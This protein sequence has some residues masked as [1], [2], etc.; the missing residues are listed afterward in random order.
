[1]RNGQMG[2]RKKLIKT[3]YRKAPPIAKLLF[4]QYER[5]PTIW[6]LH[7][8]PNGVVGGSSPVVKYSLYLMK[9]N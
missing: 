5:I 7:P 3:I 1:M 8:F 9:K 6:Q 4:Q 2:V